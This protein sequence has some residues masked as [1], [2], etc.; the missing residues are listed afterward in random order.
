MCILLE[1]FSVSYWPIREAW[2]VDFR[3]CFGGRL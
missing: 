1:A 3:A 2:E